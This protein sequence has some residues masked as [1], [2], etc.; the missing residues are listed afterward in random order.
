[1]CI[2]LPFQHTTARPQK[3]KCSISRLFSLD[4]T[5]KTNRRHTI[6]AAAVR[7]FCLAML[8]AGMRIVCV[9][10]CCTAPRHSTMWPSSASYVARGNSSPARH[11]NTTTT[12]TT[13]LWPLCRTTCVWWHPQL[14]PKDFVGV[15]F[16]C[17]HTHADNNQRIRIRKKTLKLSPPALPELYPWHNNGGNFPWNIH[18]TKA[19]FNWSE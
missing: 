18:S 7:A 1:M 15:K 2:S 17:L 19:N 12:T 5:L 14:K 8:R 16:Y 10:C 9:S 3:L 4:A 6:V 13:I 11:H